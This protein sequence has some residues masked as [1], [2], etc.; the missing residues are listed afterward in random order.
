MRAS[1]WRPT[2][3][4][5]RMPVAES[6]RITAVAERRAARIL[7]THWDGCLSA[8]VG[9]GETAV[10][11]CL[12]GGP[13]VAVLESPQ[14]QTSAA[15]PREKKARERQ[16]IQTETCIQS[17]SSTS[18]RTTHPQPRS[19]GPE[20]LTPHK[21]QTKNRGGPN[22]SPTTKIRGARTTQP[23]QGTHKENRGPNMHPVVVVNMH[24]VVVV[25]IA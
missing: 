11:A 24:P 15:C 17:S 4:C 7:P 20:R 5:T 1:F 21:E 10:A 25:N 18:P 14:L 23:P 2:S 3:F 9:V 16:A 12:V 22:G 19:E 8:C 6:A 13:A